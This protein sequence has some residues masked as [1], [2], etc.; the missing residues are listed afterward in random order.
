MWLLD[1]TQLFQ[2]SSN[3]CP[4]KILHA[5]LFQTFTTSSFS[6]QNLNSQFFYPSLPVLEIN[7]TICSWILQQE[8][9][10]A[11]PWQNHTNYIMTFWAFARLDCC[12]N[13]GII[14]HANSF[15]AF[16][17]QSYETRFRMKSWVWDYAK[18]AFLSN[19]HLPIYA[20]TCC[21]VM[22]G[23]PKKQHCARGGINKWRQT[24]FVVVA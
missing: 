22:Q 10:L 7:K 20:S 5:Q 14:S 3:Y 21:Y 6:L 16:P 15:Q 8:L 17:L 23:A 19:V 12:D 4:S 9:L 13:G 18:G 2:K 24:S 1:I 11:L